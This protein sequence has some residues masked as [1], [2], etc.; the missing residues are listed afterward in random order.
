M[1]ED[2]THSQLMA[3]KGRYHEMIT[4]G[5]WSDDV[6][7]SV[8]N[9]TTTDDH[10]GNQVEMASNIN[11][12]E[13]VFQRMSIDDEKEEPTPKSN[14]ASVQYWTVFIRT[15]KLA[16]SEWLTLCLASIAALLTG[17]SGPIYCILFGEMYGVRM[18]TS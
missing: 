18:K 7:N 14:D 8:D 12:N 6:E 11:D 17:T 16:R 13:M 1:V 4:A 3:M 5:N 2:G 15:L 9:E 10:Q